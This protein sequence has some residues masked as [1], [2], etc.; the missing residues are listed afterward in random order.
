M[1]REWGGEGETKF[2]GERREEERDGN[3]GEGREGKDGKGGEKSKKGKQAA[4]IC[5]AAHRAGNNH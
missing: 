1:P 2:Y 3:G 4:I 5:K